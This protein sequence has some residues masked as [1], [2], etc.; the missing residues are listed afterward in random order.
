[1]RCLYGDG[2]RACKILKG[3]YGG[4]GK[5][6]SGECPS[7]VH[8]S[9]ISTIL[10]PDLGASVTCLMRRGAGTCEK[11]LVHT[12][13][14]LWRYFRCLYLLTQHICYPPRPIPIWIP[15]N[16]NAMQR[17]RNALHPIA[18]YCTSLLCSDLHCARCA[19]PTRDPT[20]SDPVSI[21]ITSTLS[22]E[23]NLSKTKP[24]R[25]CDGP[26]FPPAVIIG[27]ANG[28]GGWKWRWRWE[29]TVAGCDLLRFE[30]LAVHV[31][32]R[33]GAGEM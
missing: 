13:S 29:M 28:G 20:R 18:L 2:F 9:T 6:V 17:H 27:L 22:P 21:P 15:C 4:T 11:Y 31:R 16:G 25:M 1:M 23:S 19:H 12:E 26:P 7:T 5:W 24:S 14:G 8:A 33:S 32:V 10:I 3:I 30:M